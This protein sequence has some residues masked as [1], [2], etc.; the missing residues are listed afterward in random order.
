[1]GQESCEGLSPMQPPMLSVGEK[2]L[3]HFL[4]H[5]RSGNGRV[6]WELCSVFLWKLRPFMPPAAPRAQ[7]SSN[8]QPRGAGNHTAITFPSSFCKPRKDTVIT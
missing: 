3:L 2:G 7:R 4:H 6:C 1:M 8:A 5:L